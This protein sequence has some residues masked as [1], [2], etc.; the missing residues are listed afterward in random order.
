MKY[1]VV[2]RSKITLFFVLLIAGSACKKNSSDTTFTTANSDKNFRISASTETS[3]GFKTDHTDGNGKITVTWEK[4]DSIGLFS[5]VN[6]GLKNA[7]E[8]FEILN[9]ADISNTGK[10]A[11][12]SGELSQSVDWQAD[13]YAYY[14]YAQL[15][16]ANYKAVPLSVEGQVQ[17]GENYH[18]LSKYD[19]LIGSAK[20]VKLTESVQIDFAHT[21]A[22]VDFNITIPNVSEDVEIFEIRLMRPD[23]KPIY[24]IGSIDLSTGNISAGNEENGPHHKLKLLNSILKS[25]GKFTASLAMFPADWTGET[26]IFF[27]DTSL[28][29]FKIEKTGIKMEAGKRYKSELKITEPAIPV[30]IGDYYYADGTW[31]TQLDA[32]KTVVGVV[33]Y[34]GQKGGAV[35]GHVIALHNANNNKLLTKDIVVKPPVDIPGVRNLEYHTPSIADPGIFY[36]LMSGEEDWEGYQNTNVVYTR[37][38]ETPYNQ[39]GFAL[40]AKEYAPGGVIHGPAAKGNWYTPAI[41]QLQVFGEQYKFINERIEAANGTTILFGWDD[42]LSEEE[43]NAI[44]NKK[45]YLSST[46]AYKQNEP[47]N[48][49]NRDM[50]SIRYT[51]VEYRGYVEEGAILQ[52]V[53][54]TTSRDKLAYLRPFL[55]F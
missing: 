26:I 5:L 55:T 42:R 11:V 47:A 2:S 31:S 29:T 14:P 49:V 4:S 53:D 7:N 39:C 33:V 52:T 28:G 22:I 38:N 24:T 30:N 36:F 23:N 37:R 34:K 16:N 40:L 43:N 45:Y 35:N 51:R 32:S 3:P 13:L 25:G 6:G 46:E 19:F 41:S 44:W 18:H 9:D 50:Y 54:V 8:P 20:Q 48:K 10:S 1:D 15:Q 17:D 12:F 27:V 21:M